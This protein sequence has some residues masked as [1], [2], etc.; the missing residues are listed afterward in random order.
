MDNTKGAGGPAFYTVPEAARVLRVTPATIYRAIREDAFPAVR[1]R[2]RYVIP[3]S[4]V[5][6]LAAEAAESGGCVDVAAMAAQ[7]RTAREM[8]RL[9]GGAPW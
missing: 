4:A 6:R 1:I 7:R 9:S 5:D 3:A 8:A 2:T